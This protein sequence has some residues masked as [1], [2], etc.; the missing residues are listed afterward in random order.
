MFVSF[1]VTNGVV[2]GQRGATKWVAI[3]DVVVVQFQG[4]FGCQDAGLGG[5]GPI[6]VVFIVVF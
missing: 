1:P 6:V 2:A 4:F 5:L 3:V